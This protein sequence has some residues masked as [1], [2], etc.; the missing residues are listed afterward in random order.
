MDDVV[1]RT[2]IQMTDSLRDRIKILAAI[3]RCTMQEWIE[4]RVIEAENQ[5][6]QK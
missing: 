3:E 5:L 1:F 4:K 6:Q 2:T